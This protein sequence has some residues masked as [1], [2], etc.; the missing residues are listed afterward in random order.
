MV[1]GFFF[2]SDGGIAGFAFSGSISRYVSIVIFGG[3]IGWR[4][5]FIVYG[6]NIDKILNVKD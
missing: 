6:K 5:I 4:V 3:I 1:G 2:A